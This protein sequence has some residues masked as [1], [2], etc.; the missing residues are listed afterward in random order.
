[1]FGGDF[2]QLKPIRVKGSDILWHPS[3]GGDF[4]RNLN[5]AIVLEGTHRFRDNRWY[6]NMLKRICSGQ[7]TQEDI[8][9]INTR[10][11]SVCT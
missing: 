6:G 11:I 5:C 7:I 1:M 2:Q 9:K 4:E 10:V 3:S 8:D